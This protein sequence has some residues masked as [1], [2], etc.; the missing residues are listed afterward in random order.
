M[1]KKK[2]AKCEIEA[3]WMKVG[4]RGGEGGIPGR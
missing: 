3:I 4:T 2:A 1:E